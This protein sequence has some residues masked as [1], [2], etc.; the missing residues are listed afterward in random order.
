MENITIFKATQRFITE[1]SQSEGQMLID[2][3][4]DHGSEQLMHFPT[5]EKY[6]GFITQFSS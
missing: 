6:I 4:N 3:K 2:T 1:Q 5:R